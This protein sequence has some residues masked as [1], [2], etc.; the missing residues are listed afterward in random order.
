MEKYYIFLLIIFIIIIIITF[1]FI[2]KY[3]IDIYSKVNNKADT[4]IE[5]FISTKD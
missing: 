3:I 4:Y 2:N 1:H 5:S